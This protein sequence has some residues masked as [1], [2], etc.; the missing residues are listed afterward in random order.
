[1]IEVFPKED[2]QWSWRRRDEGGKATDKPDS[3]F[4]D[5]RTA[6]GDARHAAGATRRETFY[7]DG[8]SAGVKSTPT[9]EQ[10][11][12]LRLDGTLVGELDP[13]PSRG[14]TPQHVSLTPATESGE[15]GLD[16]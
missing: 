4:P 6:I 8:K 11:V 14:G 13:A 5:R 9:Q 12:L 3:D 15:G 2:G 7:D 16:G 10:V 1:M